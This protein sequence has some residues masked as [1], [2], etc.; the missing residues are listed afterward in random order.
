MKSSHLLS[1]N[2]YVSSPLVSFTKT[3]PL[4]GH[5]D[6]SGQ[7]VDRYE[8]GQRVGYVS[9]TCLPKNVSKDRATCPMPG[10]VCTHHYLLDPSDQ[11]CRCEGEAD[12]D[13]WVSATKKYAAELRDEAT[14]GTETASLSGRLA[15]ALERVLAIERK[16]PPSAPQQNGEPHHHAVCK[17]CGTRRTY[18]VTL[19]WDHREA[20]Q[21]LAIMMGIHHWDE[22]PKG[23]AV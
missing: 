1:P 11:V 23:G 12:A 22:A 15:E 16:G 3:R 4:R 7:H 8:T 19:E 21:A 18:P 5:A 20:M 2:V 9:T 6:T 14:A 17:I 13:P 10:T